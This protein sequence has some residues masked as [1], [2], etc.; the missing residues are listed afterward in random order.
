MKLYPVVLRKNY[1]HLKYIVGV[2]YVLYAGRLRKSNN[3]KYV[4]SYI[5]VEGRRIKINETI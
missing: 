2:G 1:P 5:W 4:L 3:T